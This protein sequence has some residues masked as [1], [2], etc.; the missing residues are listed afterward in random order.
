M[1]IHA[2]SAILSAAVV[3]AGSLVAPSAHAQGARSISCTPTTVSADGASPTPAVNPIAQALRLAAPGA[4]IDL[5]MGD[6]PAFGVGFDNKNDA[7]NAPISGGTSGQPIVVRGGRGVR[8]VPNGKGDTIAICQQIACGYITFEDLA[9]VP[10]TRAGVIFYRSGPDQVH[11]GFSFHDCDILGE[12]D[13]ARA[14]GPGS[15]WGVSA[16]QIADFEWRGVSRAS[17]IE[18]IKDE[19]AFYLQN[20]LGDVRIENVEAK[21]LG[22]TFV[23]LVARSH[24]GPAATGTVTI[25]KCKV[26][27]AGIAAGDAY[28]GGYAITIAGTGPQCT[29][30]IEGNVVRAGFDAALR[31][32]TKNGEPY[33]TGACVAWDGG[34]ARANGTVIVERNEFVFAPGCGDRPLASF[35]ACASLKLDGNKFRAGNTKFAALA[36]D[37]RDELG[38]PRGK[39]N[40]KVVLGAQNELTGALEIAGAL[41]ANDPAGELKT[42]YGR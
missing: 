29:V 41:Y 14:S 35:S 10:G 37:P 42:R 20:T 21:R 18:N 11:R 1:L 2:Q 40:S 34:D 38:R 15:K 5:S 36:L 4:T 25:K 24:E 13:H 31:K 39:A 26:D 27:D 6:Y 16:H 28:K 23:Q 3:L 9:I 30:R 17:R 32:L 22:R 33:G 8:I 7:S 12:Y 19:H